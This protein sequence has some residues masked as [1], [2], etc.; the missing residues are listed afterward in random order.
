[1][2]NRD[3]ARIRLISVRT[4]AEEERQAVYKNFLLPLYKNS[5]PP[6]ERRNETSWQQLISSHPQFDLALIHDLQ[7]EDNSMPC[8][9]L[10][11][12]YLDS[13]VY[14]EHFALS[15]ERRNGGIG[16]ATISELLRLQ[17]GN[18]LPM[19]LEVELPDAGEMAARRIKFYERLGFATLP[20]DYMQPVYDC[21]GETALEMKVMS[22]KPLSPA[23]YKRITE[24][25][26]Q[27]VYCLA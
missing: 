17:A 10:S 11:F 21:P 12:W 1:M 26:E 24:E 3:K 9:F 25:I 7:S 13:C 23:E 22:S 4:L 5:F 8:G 6:E 2:E 18:P 15:P 14:G 27:R 19:V 20:Y 16:S